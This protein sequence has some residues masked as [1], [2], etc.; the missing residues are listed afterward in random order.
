MRLN[1][2]VT[3]RKRFT[4]APSNRLWHCHCDRV[5]YV[6][7]SIRYKLLFLRYIRNAFF[8]LSLSFAWTPFNLR[9]KKR[10]QNVF[11]PHISFISAK[12]CFNLFYLNFY[13]TQFVTNGIRYFHR[14]YH[15]PHEAGNKSSKTLFIISKWGLNLSRNHLNHSTD[16]RKRCVRHRNDK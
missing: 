12:R 14:I 3:F 7:I 16:A 9:R 8:S 15:K 1:L 4:S 2:M 11:V 5:I 13:I 10:S 6:N